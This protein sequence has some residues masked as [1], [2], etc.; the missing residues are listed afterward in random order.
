MSRPPSPFDPR[1]ER[2]CERVARA[3]GEYQERAFAEARE[4]LQGLLSE[5]RSL[6]LAAPDILWGLG[7]CADSLHDF[8]S[9]I[10]YCRMALEIDPLSPSYR[11]SWAIVVGRVRAA[12]LSE[13]RP[14]DDSEL[15]TLCRLLTS[16][17]AA[18]EAVHLRLA[19]VLLMIGDIEEAKALVL[20][21]SRLSPNSCEALALLAHLAVI[22]E[23]EE[24]AERVNAMVTKPEQ[25][26]LPI[27]I[28]KP[29]AQA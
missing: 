22:T 9:A 12:I 16:N 10:S 1:I 19:K 2:I 6:G 11:R 14:L 13:D 25:P 17:G 7:C 3:Q 15:L 5:A 4:E 21:V 18:D 27:F 20:A 26:D 28:A 29:M 24:L 23:D 8:P